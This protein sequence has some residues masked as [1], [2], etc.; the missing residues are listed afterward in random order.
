VCSPTE[1]GGRDEA[2]VANGGD[3][4]LQRLR[5]LDGGYL[6]T[7][8]KQSEGETVGAGRRTGGVACS[9]RQ[10]NDGFR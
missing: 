7:D 10:P 2:S 6:R 1:K 5:A 4:M 8:G 3:S 9:H